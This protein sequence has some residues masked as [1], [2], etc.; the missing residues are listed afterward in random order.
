[1][2]VQV[3]LTLDEDNFK[4]FKDMLI[5]TKESLMSQIPV[6]ES[7]IKTKEKETDKNKIRNYLTYVLT[8]L[9]L[10]AS[11]LGQLP[12]TYPNIIIP[13]GNDKRLLT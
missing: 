9:A 12:E 10:V 3:S 13:D 4:A 1:M 8:Q 5:V 11:I 7:G 2:A 6:L